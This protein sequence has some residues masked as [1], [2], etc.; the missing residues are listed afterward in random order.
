MAGTRRTAWEESRRTGA[1]QPSGCVLENEGT[2]DLT[3]REHGTSIFFSLHCL[4]KFP[5]SSSPGPL[6]SSTEEK[7]GGQQRELDWE[8]RPL[9]MGE[10]AVG[11]FFTVEAAV[12]D[13]GVPCSRATCILEIVI[14]DCGVV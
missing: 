13:A 3:G 4:I 12:V 11:F 8:R 7:G 5:Y 10:A 9:Q 1:E 2:H 6:A 14:G